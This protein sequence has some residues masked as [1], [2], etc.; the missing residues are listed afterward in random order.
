[1]ANLTESCLLYC[2]VLGVLVP[3]FT[4]LSTTIH[5]SYAPL[6]I[7]YARHLLHATG[8]D[9]GGSLSCL[10]TGNVPRTSSPNFASFRVSMCVNYLLLVLALLVCP[11]NQLVLH[12]LLSLVALIS[13]AL[14]Y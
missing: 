11:L 4:L 10:L 5:L 2:T 1:M 3:L 12:L 14:P 13:I 9:F 7:N 8:T 6:D